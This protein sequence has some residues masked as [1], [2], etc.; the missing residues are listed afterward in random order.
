MTY[1]ATSRADW[2]DMMAKISEDML[3][4]GQLN[5]GTVHA[6]KTNVPMHELTHERIMVQ[7]PQNKQLLQEMM[8]PNLPWAEDHFQERVSG[9]PLNPPPS[10]EWWPFAQQGNE[11]HKQDGKFSHTYPERFWPRYTGDGKANLG[12]RFLYGDLDNL[13]DLLRK[14]LGTRQAYL[15]VWFPEDLWAAQAGERVPCTL[16]YHFLLTLHDKDFKLD[17]EYHMRSCDFVRFFTDDAYMA[18]R[19]LQWVC[20]RVLVEP[21]DLYMNIGS[22]HCFVDDKLTL[23]NY[24]KVRQQQWFE[25]LATNL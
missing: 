10:N 15:P 22:F 20:N 25:R 4:S 17:I 19:L 9:Q 14:N 12:I 1:F 24:R 11:V 21:G 2:V 23:E 16:G 8:Q 7:V 5:R 18:A 3:K 6:Q 13:V